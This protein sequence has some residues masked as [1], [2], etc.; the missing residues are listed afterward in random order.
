MQE[1][2]KDFLRRQKSADLEVE[3]YQKILQ[4]NKKQ[5]EEIDELFYEDS[6]LLGPLVIR[7]GDLKKRL[8]KKLSEMNKVLLEQIKRKVEDSKKMIGTE[9]DNVLSIIKKQDYKNI[10][11]VTETRKFI[12]DLP[13]KMLNIQRLITGVNAKIGV[14]DE[15]LFRLEEPEIVSIWEAF[16]RPREI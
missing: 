11:E 7:V 13:D 2:R 9:V 1:D 4:D 15:N 6:L 12:K 14:L 3:G 8:K 10:E 16:A 5:E